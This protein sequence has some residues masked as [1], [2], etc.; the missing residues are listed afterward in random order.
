[1]ECFPGIDYDL[2]WVTKGQ[3]ED[4]IDI[5]RAIVQHMDVDPKDIQNW[6]HCDRKVDACEVMI[7]D[8]IVDYIRPCY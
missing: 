5:Q 8:M 2:V 7:G 4:V 1:M 3:S 6:I